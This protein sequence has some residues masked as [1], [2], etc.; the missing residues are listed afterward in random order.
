MEDIKEILKYL[1][2]STAKYLFE[3]DPQKDSSG[4]N[5][6]SDIRPDVLYRAAVIWDF[7]CIETAEIE[8]G[9]LFIYARD[10]MMLVG[11]TYVTKGLW[12][13]IQNELST[14]YNILLA[15]GKYT[16][17]KVSET[18][19]STNDAWSYLGKYLLDLS[20]SFGT[21]SYANEM[22]RIFC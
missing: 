17:T 9:K 12:S 18:D 7:V 13:Y 19:T 16:G 6:I 22:R 10:P 20:N 11:Q 1:A 21:S 3:K 14:K 15:I 4:I 8:N 2:E 5:C